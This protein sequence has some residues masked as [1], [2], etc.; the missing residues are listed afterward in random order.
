MEDNRNNGYEKVCCMCR[1]TEN[2][3]GKMITLP[4]GLNVCRDCMQR[5]FDMMMGSGM[6]W[7]KMSGITPEL[8]KNMYLNPMG[9]GDGAQKQENTGTAAGKKDD[10]SEAEKQN[11]VDNP[12]EADTDEDAEQTVVDADE[13]EDGDDFEEDGDGS[14][15]IPLGNIFG[16][17]VGQID[18]GALMGQG[19]KRRKKKKK[20]KKELFKLSEIPAPHAIK[21]QLD[22]YVIGQ[23]QA[24]KVISV[25]VYN[26]Y[27]RVFSKTSPDAEKYGTDIEIEKSNILMIGPTGCGKTEIWRSLQK[28]FPFI[29]IVNGP[30][31]AC[32]GWK[33]SYHVKDI[34]LEEPAE[35]VKKML[36]VIDEADKLFDKTF[37]QDVAG[38]DYSRKIQNEFLKIMD[39]DKVDF[40]SEGNDAK[41]TTIDCSHVSF[42]FC[43]SFETLLQNREDKPATIG[44]FQ[45]TA[46]DEE[47]ESITIEDLVEY[48]NVRREIAGRIQQIVA[49][50]A[51]TV[52]DFEH[53]LNSRKQMSPIRQLEKLYMVNLSVDDK[54]K[55]I[56]A[57]KAATKNLGCRYM[58]SQIQSML[59]EKMFD[60]PDCR[61]FKLSLVEEKEEGLPWCAA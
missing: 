29:K 59:D 33:G 14:E 26:H 50:N 56:L 39:G 27:K 7:T 3:A 18:L 43:G 44:F 46:P 4:G 11:S 30:Q 25:A 41:K 9:S 40:V 53:I 45:N 21:A 23:E 48:G 17:P 58:R 61:N 15:G 19:H 51:L 28:R 22:E 34:F 42:V 32:D 47:A 38:V 55:R 12:T 49:L 10:V 57:E 13:T 2:Q 35:K 6:D 31:I 8:L 5:S 1:R 36:I 37:I 54:T 52:D 24:K 20:V 16:I 60:D